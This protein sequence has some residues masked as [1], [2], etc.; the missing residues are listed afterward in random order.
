M[1]RVAAP[2]AK[3]QKG[4][5]GLGG[6]RLQGDQIVVRNPLVLSGNKDPYDVCDV[7]S[8]S[9]LFNPTLAQHMQY[10]VGVLAGPCC[11]C[12]CVCVFKGGLVCMHWISRGAVSD[13]KEVKVKAL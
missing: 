7:F 2:S 10:T 9:C 1:H 12:V 5:W 6:R 8:A 13:S 4:G 11:W 3:N